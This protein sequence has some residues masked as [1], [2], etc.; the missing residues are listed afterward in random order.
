MAALSSSIVVAALLLGSGSRT[1]LAIQWAAL[2]LRGNASYSLVHH[3]HNSLF[4]LNGSV[5]GRFNNNQ[6][7]M[8]SLSSRIVVDVQLS[9]SDGRTPLTM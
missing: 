4:I 9:W 5:P 3:N 7:L 8:T 6:V 2:I 1:P